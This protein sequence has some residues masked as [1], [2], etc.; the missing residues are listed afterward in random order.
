M[1]PGEIYVVDLFGRDP[2]YLGHVVR[3]A[4]LAVY[5]PRQIADGEDPVPFWPV[6]VRRQQ[7]RVSFDS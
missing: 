1:L 6:G 7:D 3:G 5:Y 2:A 4:R